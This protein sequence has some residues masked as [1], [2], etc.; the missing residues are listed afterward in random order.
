MNIRF[1]A[2]GEERIFQ[3]ALTL[4]G[5]EDNDRSRL[6][7]ETVCQRAAAYCGREDIP[8]AMEGPLAVLLAGELEGGTPGGVRSVKRGDTTITY[9]EG[10]DPMAV[11]KPFVRLRSPAKR[12]WCV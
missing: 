12:W 11:L 6:L 5:G 1:E 2:G 8:S 7:L 4:C 9:A 10:S 3:K